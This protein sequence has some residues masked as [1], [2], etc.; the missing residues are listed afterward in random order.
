MTRLLLCAATLLALTATTPAS[1]QS[2]GPW[3]SGYAGTRSDFPLSYPPPPVTNPNRH[4]PNAAQPARKND[5][6]D[7]L[8]ALHCNDPR[9]RL[10]RQCCRRPI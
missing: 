10:R 3:S 5:D 4:P 1:A 2:A 9:S 6:H 7:T 8:T